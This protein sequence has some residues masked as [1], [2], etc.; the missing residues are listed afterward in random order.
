[1]NFLNSQDTKEKKWG[2]IATLNAYVMWGILPLY[3]KLLNH[4]SPYEILSHRIIWSLVFLLVILIFSRKIG[5]TIKEL[6]DTFKNPKNLL[7]IF[8]A[9]IFI[10]VN[11]YT[12][13]WAVNNNHVVDASLGYYINPLVSVLLGIVVLKERLSIWQTISFL[14]A[15]LGVINLAWH[16]GKIPWIALVLA[17]SFAIYGLLK[18]ITNLKALSSMILETFLICPVALFYIGNLYAQGKGAL[19]PGETGLTMLLVG[20][21]V[22][23]AVPLLLYASGVKYLTLSSVGFLQYVEPTLILLLGVFLYNEPFVIT[24]LV[25]FAF[26]WLALIIYSLS[27]TKI[28]INLEGKLI[29]KKLVHV[30]EKI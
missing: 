14:L 3:W 5:S 19:T 17:F 2:V 29:K 27:N 18:K 16:F 7:I 12:Y 8:M 20:T 22:I 28:F 30:N 15:L 26:I 13:I 6:Y 1:M 23:T 11:W 25:S 10:S 9:A 21:G 24:H 4:V